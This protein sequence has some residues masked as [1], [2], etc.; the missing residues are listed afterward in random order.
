MASVM[1]ISVPSFGWKEVSHELSF[2]ED[3]LPQPFIDGL[4]HNFCFSVGA[5]V[6]S[7]IFS[8]YIWGD[9]PRNKQTIWHTTV[10]AFAN[11]V[12]IF[13]QVWPTAIETA[14]W[15]IANYDGYLWDM[16]P[17]ADIYYL[18]GFL[19]G[20]MLVDTL[21]M[22]IWWKDIMASMKLPLYM[23]M[24]GHHVLSLVLWPYALTSHCVV[25]PVFYYVF[26]E[27]SNPFLNIQ[28]LIDMHPKW[29]QYYT[30]QSMTKLAFFSAFFIVRIIPA[31][32]FIVALMLPYQYRH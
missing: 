8:P 3:S 17:N 32:F 22:V 12:L 2:K 9:L 6:L 7:H 25:I 1:G 31:P 24:F 13:P 23:Q 5:L 4:V 14:K 29:S 15:V 11:S 30:L 19:L 21:A 26:T 27:V 16:K 20:Y 18:V 10:Q 28:A